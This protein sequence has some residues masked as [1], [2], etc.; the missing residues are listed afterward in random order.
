[1][2]SMTFPAAAGLTDT[3]ADPYLWLEDVAGEEALAWVKERN[4]RAESQLR[5][6]RYD[7]LHSEL[8]GIFEAS[9]RIPMVVRRGE[10]LYNFWTDAEHPQGI[11]RRTTLD[12][13]RSESPDWEILLDLDQLSVQEGTTWVWHGAQVLRPAPGDPYR[14]ALIS[15]SPGGSDADVTRE[16]DLL[17]RSFVEPA[18]GGFFKPQGKGSLSWI[19]EDSVYLTHDAGDDAVTT[20]GY[21]RVAQLWRRGEALE[22][23]EP[24]LSVAQDELTV[25]AGYDDTPGH[26]RHVGVRALGFYDSETYLIET[27]DDGV[28]QL[29]RIEV[30]T[31]VR[32]SLHRDL[33]MFSPRGDVTIA[34]TAL[35]GGSLAVAEIKDFLA[36]TAELRVLFAPTESMSLRDVTVTRDTIVLTIMDT[37]V[38]RAEAHWRGS[39]GWVSRPVLTDVGGTLSISAVDSRDSEELW[40]TA[41]GFLTP[42]S[43]YLVDLEPMRAAESAAGTSSHRGA[44]SGEE[45]GT[46]DMTL[47]KR[48]P[49]RFDATGMSVTQRFATSAD[50]TS[51]PYFLIGKVAGSAAA[52]DAGHDDGSALDQPAPTVLYGYGGFEISMTPGY[53][54]A[55]GKA[56]LEPG[57]VLAI[58][59]IRGGGEFGPSWHSAALKEN[60]HR[61]Y[62]DFAA[63]AR[64][65]V[66]TGVTTVSRLACRGGSN[67][68]LLTGNMLTQ[69]PELFGAVVIQVP[70]LDMKRF[71]ELLAGAS[72]RAEYGDPATDDWDFIRTF[73][74]YHLLRGDQ[75]YPPVLLTTSTRDDRVHPGHARKMTAALEELGAE[76]QYWENTEGGHGGA[77]NPEQQATMNA[78]LYRYLWQRLG[79]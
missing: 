69:Y 21:P 31:D 70:L 73:S 54:G 65:L 63:V 15:L 12:S 72:W 61:A 9:D 55:V 32:V 33:V 79:D 22:S 13:Y 51:I 23:A 62:E 18:E 3:V 19:D 42:A 59:N 37:V 30:P 47:L 36:G 41:N 8:R 78:L 49:E 34:G 75:Q 10:H 14:W 68:G 6:D 64:D 44:V 24:V 39:R 40:V 7:A 74:P 25:G 67:G 28:H 27:D 52:G 5:D 29:R 16:F 2:A 60:R 77:A 38:D 11:W 4:R 66:A 53:L 76:V 71:A 17:T 20:S 48:A 43:L 50:G 35:P 26:E 45:P 58:A 46:E 56:W 1:M 57:G